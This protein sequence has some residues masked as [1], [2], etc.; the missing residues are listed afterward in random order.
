MHRFWKETDPQQRQA[1]LTNFQKNDGLL[2]GALVIFYASNQLQ[3][4]AGPSLTDP[5]FGSW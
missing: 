5:L 3:G 2:G 4:E 1:Q